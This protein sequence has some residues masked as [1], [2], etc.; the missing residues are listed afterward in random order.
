LIILELGGRG[1]TSW[2]TCMDKRGRRVRRSSRTAKQEELRVLGAPQITQHT[3][4]HT[5]THVE[6]H[7]FFCVV[8]ENL[9][10][11]VVKRR[12]KELALT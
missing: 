7:T 2:Q 8:S 4:T 10:V 5:H 1:L 12:G 3:H 11:C 9:A 6:S